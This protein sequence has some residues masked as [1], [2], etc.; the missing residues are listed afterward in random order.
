MFARIIICCCT[1][2]LLATGCGGEDDSASTPTEPTSVP[3]A[4]LTVLVTNDDGIGAPGLDALVSV[5][6][7]M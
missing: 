3:L 5:L 6:K 7:E 2:G 4:P 1:I